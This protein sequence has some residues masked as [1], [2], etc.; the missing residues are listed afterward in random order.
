MDAKYT[1]LVKNTAI[2]SIGEFANKILSFL[3]VPLF[4]YVLTTEEYG[5][6]DLFMTSISL[7]IP[8]MTIQIQQA[9]LRFLLGKEIDQETVASNCWLVFLIGIVCS[10]ALFP[11][12]YFLFEDKTL[13]VLFTVMIAT[14]CFSDIFSQFLRAIGKVLEYTAKS[15]LGTFINLSC[16]V[17]LVLVFRKG[18]HGYLY[19]ALISQIFGIV[20]LLI[21]GKLYPLLNLR[22]VDWQA[23]SN[24]IRYSI[25]MIPNTLMWW[26]MSAGDKY[27]INYFL[28]DGAN[29]VF[30]L[31]QKVPSIVMLFYSFFYQAWQMASIEERNS[32]DVQSFSQQVYHTINALLMLLVSGIVLFVKPLYTI[33]MSDQ[34]A[35]AWSYVP[36][37]SL[38]VA[39][40]CQ[41]SF[42]GVIYTT[43]KKTGKALKTTV[44]G[45]VVN[46]FLNFLLIQHFGLQGVAVATLL[47]YVAV[48]VMRAVDAKPVMKIRYD[49]KR[50]G[51]STI[52][53]IFQIVVTLH[54]DALI[55]WIGIICVLL[56]LIFFRAELLKILAVVKSRLM[57]KG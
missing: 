4:T 43:T 46:V 39:F 20:Y 1:K 47:G 9:M 33:V 2:F 50:L 22:H 21:V 38:A 57:K 53:I 54:T 41:A 11:G 23:L 56:Q 44:I 17:L 14:N 34:F 27:I 32:E 31:A 3:I 5:Q 37:L 48:V 10:V 29:G 16:T 15:V 13:A 49:L 36:F 28:G 51:L 24:M 7:M 8:I 35:I 30:S 40:N 52:V 25:P 45:A 6:I 42:F 26:V 18:V 55:S 19:A 12:Y